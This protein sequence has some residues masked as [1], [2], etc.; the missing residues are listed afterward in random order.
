MKTKILNIYEGGSIDL[1][2]PNIGTIELIQMLGSGAFGS[3]WKVIDLTT[4]K[5]YALKVIQGIDPT[6]KMAKRI[7][8]E[9]QV[10]IESPYAI[11]TIGLQEWDANTFLILFEYTSGESLDKVLKTEK[12]T[13]DR[14]RQIIYEILLGVAAT[15]NSN[16][17]HRDLK[18]AN[19]LITDRGKVKL[20]DFGIS[21][22]N[23]VPITIGSEVMGTLPWMP[24]ETIMYGSK[25]ADAKTDIYALGHIFY[26][27]VTGKHFWD[28]QEWCELADFGAYLNQNPQPV[29]AIDLSK[30]TSD[31]FPN[32][33][34][35]IARMVK[36]DPAIRYS[37]IE[38]IVA[39][40]QYEPMPT[41]TKPDFILGSP[42]LRVESGSNQGAMTLIDLVAGNKLILGRLD[43]AGNDTSISREHLEFSRGD[44]RYYVRDLGSKNGTWI[45]GVALTSTMTSRELQHGDAI[46]VG[47]IFLKFLRSI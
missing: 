23:D 35:T 13:P 34:L 8:L 22:F 12:L 21:K 30:F 6:S 24:P 46:K 41:F 45:K 28:E 44:D 1:D 26:E 19:I 29:D 17:I 25:L 11:A 10:K 9:A 15:H 37:N 47:D 14:K 4:K 18:P 40:L 16:I 36:L 31:L 3:V 32:F 7:R 38:E 27:L 2:I 33:K 39:D 20:L 5:I 43:L 42:V